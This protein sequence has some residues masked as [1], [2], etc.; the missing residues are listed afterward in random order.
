MEIL[1]GIT[2]ALVALIIILKV[3]RATRGGLG[4]FMKVAIPRTI[5]KPLAMGTRLDAAAALKKR[6]YKLDQLRPLIDG[7]RDQE[8]VDLYW[9][10]ADLATAIARPKA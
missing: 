4:D 1:F 7:G 3:R 2:I 5:D 10:E 8:L 6:G 9:K